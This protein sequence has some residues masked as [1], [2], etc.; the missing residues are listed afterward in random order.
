MADSTPELVNGQRVYRC[1]TLT[2]TKM[3][4]VAV[5]GWM[6]WGDFVYTLMESVWPQILPLF[7]LKNAGA[8]PQQV[9]WI[10]TTI[11]QIIGFVACPIISF[12]SDRHRGKWGRR[13]PFIFWT[14]PFLSLFLGALGFSAEIIDWMNW[15]SIPRLLG[16]SPLATALVIIGLLGVGFNFF[17]E[18]V[19]SVYWYLFNDVVP[20]EKMGQFLGWFRFVGAG[21]T[22]LFQ[23]FVFPHTLEP[24]GIKWIFLGAAALYLV[25]FG[26][27]CWQ[28]KEGEY[29]PVT[30][31][32]KR[33]GILE[34]IALFFR[35]CFTHPIYILVFVST[36]LAAIGGLASI[37]GQVFLLS[38][39]ITMTQLGMVAGIT[40]FVSM[41][42]Q[43]PCG[44]LVDKVHPLRVVLVAATIGVAVTVLQYFFLWDWSSYLTF[45]TAGLVV[46]NIANAAGIP[47]LMRIFPQDKYGQFCSANGA[48]KS[49]AQ[50]VGSFAAG[51]FVDWIS[52][53]GKYEPGYR[54]AFLWQAAFAALSLLCLVGVYVYWKRLGGDKGYAPPMPAG[55][56]EEKPERIS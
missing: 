21:A 15:S 45:T 2:Y 47:L 11:P 20:K 22:M 51:P 14:A 44:M 52:N 29:P 42:L 46:G 34:Q 6:L 16:M 3:G 9:L 10:K 13:I 1:G 12:K 39:N 36:G 33:T 5:F 30:D 26:L 43:P 24:G 17:N 53:Y 55:V 54:L 8:S 37:G 4:L 49:L 19:G 48:T 25:G 56:P 50:V 23:W 28:V 35:D 31:V 41:F 38:L 32:T 7:L 27:M 18:F 40:A